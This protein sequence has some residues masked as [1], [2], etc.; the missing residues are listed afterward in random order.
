MLSSPP[1]LLSRTAVSPSVRSVMNAAPPVVNPHP[2]VNPIRVCLRHLCSCVQ[3]TSVPLICSA[4][5]PPLLRQRVCVRMPSICTIVTTKV[6]DVHHCY[7]TFERSGDT[8]G[9]RVCQPQKY[10]VATCLHSVHPLLSSICGKPHTREHET[11]LLLCCYVSPFGTPLALLDLFFCCR[12]ANH[13]CTRPI[14]PVP[15]LILIVSMCHCRP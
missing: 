12:R 8:V 10:R 14:P 11:P 5:S 6:P 15:T 7:Y 1:R 9:T 13:V 3:D 4:A 2:V